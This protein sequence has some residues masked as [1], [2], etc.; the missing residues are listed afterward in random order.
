MV[1]PAPPLTPE[2]IRVRRFIEDSLLE[3]LGSVPL[4]LRATAEV[5]PPMPGGVEERMRDALHEA[6]YIADRAA[7]GLPVPRDPERIADF[8]LGIQLGDPMLV[9]HL[10]D[11]LTERLR[12]HAARMKRRAPNAALRWAPVIRKLRSNILA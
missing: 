11:E 5:V 10:G 3:T 2:A 6:A 1:S 12:Q 9:W 4:I 7:V 8:I